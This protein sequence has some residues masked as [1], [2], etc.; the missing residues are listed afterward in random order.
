ML[1]GFMGRLPA[2][3]SYSRWAGG[4]RPLLITRQ[5]FEKTILRFK[6]MNASNKLL[7]R[8]LWSCSLN[9][10][11]CS[12]NLIIKC[13]S[14]N[15]SILL[16]P[17]AK[18]FV[19]HHIKINQLLSATCFSFQNLFSGIKYGILIVCICKHTI[20]MTLVDLKK[21]LYRFCVDQN[22]YAVKK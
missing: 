7:R 6:R 14:S 3:S 22:G 8:I 20:H 13:V 19:T 5:R 18:T 15:I 2:H 21:S 11:L 17:S 4:R 16:F 1:E 12:L 9:N 10:A